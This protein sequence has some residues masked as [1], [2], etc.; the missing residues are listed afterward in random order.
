MIP[1]ERC[2][3]N[4]ERTS[5]SGDSIT[6]SASQRLLCDRSTNALPVRRIKGPGSGADAEVSVIHP[7]DIAMDIMEKLTEFGADCA[8]FADIDSLRDSPSER[9]FPKMKDHSR[10]H[11]A[12]EITTGLPHGAVYWEPD[13][14][15]VVVFA[16][17]HPA[18]RPEMDWWC[19]EI[20]PPGN[21][22]LLAISRRLKAYMAQA[23]PE[24][25]VY[26]KRYHVER[27]GIYLKDAAVAAGLGCIGRN[28]L[29]VTP[30]YGPRVRLRALT[31]SVALP[32]T[33][34]ADFD[35]C[36]GCDAPCLAHCPQQAFKDQIYTPEETGLGHLPG[37]DGHFFRASCAAEMKK[38]EDGAAVGMMP[39]VCDHPEKII[40]YCRN[41]EL[42]CRIG[43]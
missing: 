20:D 13:A 38:N 24:V 3:C 22:K 10:D 2:L 27:G 41:C 34:P 43:R 15:S 19:G 39:E 35:P 32:P 12:G 14:K 25:K 17:A 7:S 8:G 36:L 29:L 42:F 33:G 16:V 37:R 1:P 11:F 5:P 21:K 28:N 26:S 23:W 18:D 4:H 6:R 40:R 30:K 31:V 9:L